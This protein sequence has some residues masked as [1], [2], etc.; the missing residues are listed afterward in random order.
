M[1]ITL[2]SEGILPLELIVTVRNAPRSDGE[3]W[4]VVQI[5][6]YA[7]NGHL[8]AE[9]I[10]MQDLPPSTCMAIIGALHEW[11][12]TRRELQRELAD[13]V[14]RRDMRDTGRGH[15]VGP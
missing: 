6:A 10:L 14:Y 9:E 12:H 2:H 15:L 1:K 4:D 13:I 3:A 5:T 8:V 11:D 7:T